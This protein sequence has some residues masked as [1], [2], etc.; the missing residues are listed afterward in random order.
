MNPEALTPSD[1]EGTSEVGSKVDFSSFARFGDGY[2]S[3]NGSKNSYYLSLLLS[4]PILS[5]LGPRHCI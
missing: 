4:R 3:E 2:V 5:L 1:G